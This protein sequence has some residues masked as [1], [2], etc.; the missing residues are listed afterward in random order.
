MSPKLSIITI[1]LNNATGLRKTIDSVVSQTF[2]DYEYI[3]I[4]G[5]STDGSMAVIKE[6][7]NQITFWISEVDHGI[8]NA[9]NKGIMQAKG[10]YFLFLN[11]GDMLVANN[12]TE[13]MLDNM[14]ECSILYGNM[15]R[16]LG[17]KSITDKRFRGRNITML[18]MFRE[19]LYHSSAYIK[20]DLFSKYGLYDESLKI[21]SDWKFF[22]IAL[23]LNAEPVVYKDID[24]CLVDITGIS[25]THSDLLIQE[26]KK[27]LEEL[28]PK[29][30]LDDYN[31]FEREAPMIQRLKKCRMGWYFFHKFYKI[32]LKYDHFNTSITPT[33][34]R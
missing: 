10:E 33:R 22:L 21:A 29:P 28:L 9:M 18:D 23:G 5:G 7:E 11:S 2:T 31:A 8:Y 24:V 3:I 19:T 27:V 32:L 25:R 17:G 13:R 6:Y 14:P 20:K 26:R 1:N 15:Q 34:S 30:I 16:D 12:V 4:D